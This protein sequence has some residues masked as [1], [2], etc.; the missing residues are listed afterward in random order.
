MA[1]HISA[2]SSQRYRV[3]FTDQTGR[4]LAETTHG[5]TQ[6][7]GCLG[8]DKVSIPVARTQVYLEIESSGAKLVEHSTHNYSKDGASEIY[9]GF[10]AD[11]TPKFHALAVRVYFSKLNG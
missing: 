7:E 2:L 5:T 8:M 3:A 11:D 4:V 10:F 1:Y 6:Y 9:S